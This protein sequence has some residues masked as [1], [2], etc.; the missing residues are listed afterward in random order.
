[1]LGRR[2]LRVGEMGRE[3]ASWERMDRECVGEEGE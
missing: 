1:M 2:R 3:W